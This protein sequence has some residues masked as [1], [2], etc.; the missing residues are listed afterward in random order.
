V[1]PHWRPGWDAATELA[2]ALTLG[3]PLAFEGTVDASSPSSAAG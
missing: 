3:R 2:E 1:S